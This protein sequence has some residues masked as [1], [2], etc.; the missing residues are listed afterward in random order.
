MFGILTGT[1][2][3]SLVSISMFKS[4]V[5]A[6]VDCNNKKKKIKISQKYEDKKY[7]MQS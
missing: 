3:S 1:G 7:S 6:T 2:F 5:L 4:R